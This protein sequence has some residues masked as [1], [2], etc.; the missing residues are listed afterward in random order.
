ML[1]TGQAR[2]GLAHSTKFFVHAQ[3]SSRTEP[4]PAC[5]WDGRGKTRRARRWEF[6]AV[7]YQTRR[8][9]EQGMVG[10]ACL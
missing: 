10:L 4:D 3:F 9:V 6:A 1:A 8:A 7:G 5:A 2:S